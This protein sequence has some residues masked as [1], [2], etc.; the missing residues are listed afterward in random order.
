MTK[1]LGIGL[2]VTGCVALLGIGI[3]I[4]VVGGVSIRT[5]IA[6]DMA[7]LTVFDPLLPGTFVKPT[8]TV[9]KGS[10]QRTVELVLVTQTK[11]YRLV[12]T[13][14]SFGNAR[15]RIPCNIVPGKARLE[16]VGKQS[17]DV[18]SSVSVEILPPGPD[19]VR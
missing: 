15:M 19:C 6:P 12:H 18:I 7:A 13:N 1:Q 3:I 5:N 14:F 11:K 9:A 2:L 10:V 16:L 4:D 17:R 8:W